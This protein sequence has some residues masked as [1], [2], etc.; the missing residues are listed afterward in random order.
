M[1]EPR[2][3]RPPVPKNLAKASLLSVRLSADERRALERAADRKGVR[4]S[5]WAH[6]TLVKTAIK[7]NC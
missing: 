1:K 6:G 4:L 5:E 3:G 7:S 2:I